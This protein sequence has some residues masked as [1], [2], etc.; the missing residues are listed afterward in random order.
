MS[1]TTRLST[2]L[3]LGA[4]AVPSS[5]TALDDGGGRWLPGRILVA[6]DSGDAQAIRALVHEAVGGKLVGDLPVI[7]HAWQIEVPGKVEPDISKLVDVDFQDR[8][9]PQIRWIQPNYI[10]H[11][12]L[13][14]SP[15]DASFWPND[16][17]FWPAIFG[18]PNRCAGQ[19]SQLLQS[20][21]WPIGYNLRDPRGI[22]NPHN[23]LEPEQ[24]LPPDP[25][26]DEALSAAADSS[27]DVLPVWN[28]LGPPSSRTH[29]KSAFEN[30]KFVW[31]DGDMR[32]S[33]I[34]VWDTGVS[35]AP[36]LQP[37]V[38][39][40]FG[41][42]TQPQRPNELLSQRDRD[43]FSLPYRDGE[44]LEDFEGSRKRSTRRTIWASRAC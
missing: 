24:Q 14:A 43:Y 36:D 6:F 3:M 7:P 8:A 38:A 26:A 12:Q 15:R 37:Q 10:A 27:I 34:A 20:S 4:L 40:V 30:G 28:A 9:L 22:W 1:R 2:M 41:V 33:G 32:R 18:N 16:P 42:G 29:G 5:A 13:D 39:A 19:Q 11:V 44:P 35:D 31:T 25:Q 21:L 23:P 17:Y